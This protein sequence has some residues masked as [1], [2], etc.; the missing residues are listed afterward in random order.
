M[1]IRAAG[2]DVAFQAPPPTTTSSSGA[3]PSFSF[4]IGN[5]QLARWRH[6]PSLS[7][8]LLDDMFSVYLECS[9]PSFKVERR[10]RCHP[11]RPYVSDTS[12]VDLAP[13]AG[14]QPAQTCYNEQQGFGLGDYIHVMTPSPLH[15]DVKFPPPR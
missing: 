13:L 15:V 10:R 6:R 1:A 8:C 14:A 12:L 7:L 4:S 5:P 3:S 2:R 9:N 11:A